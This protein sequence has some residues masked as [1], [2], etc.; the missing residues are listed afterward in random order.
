MAEQIIPKRCIGCN[1]TKP[2]SE[3]FKNRSIKDGY[4]SYCKL[5]DKLAVRKYQKTKKG[6]A[7]LREA[8]KRYQQ[9]KKGK[10][11]KKRYQQS[12]KGKAT[13]KRFYIQ[14]INRCKA[15]SAIQHAIKNGKLPQQNTLQC[16]YCPAQAKQYHH[17]SYA[18]KHYLNVIPIC[19]KCH[20]KIHKKSA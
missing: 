10:A 15:T 17:P 9:T 8:R 3:F 7:T 5:C 6:R 13:K 14:N 2:L 16:H 1:H 18:P 20:R 11:I 4:S 19:R 12:K